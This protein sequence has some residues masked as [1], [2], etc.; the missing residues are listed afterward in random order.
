MCTNKTVRYLCDQTSSGF[1]MPQ[2]QLQLWTTTIDR[3]LAT[4]R[5]ANLNN[6]I[7]F[8]DLP[9]F[10]WLIVYF[11]VPIVQFLPLATRYNAITHC[12]TQIPELATRYNVNRVLIRQVK[13][14][15][16]R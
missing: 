10:E 16:R 13:Y 4:F 7:G 2:I 12:A 5:V 3:G 1:Y 15:L 6:S 8:L 14:L 9:L 11:S